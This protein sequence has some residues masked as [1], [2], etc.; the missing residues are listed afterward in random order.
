MFLRVCGTCAPLV[1]GAIFYAGSFGKAY[2]RDFDRPP[3]EVAAAL[4]DLDVSGISGASG[5]LYAALPTVRSER[6]AD[7]FRWTI[8]S[9]SEV[10]LVM[11][12]RITP[13][14]G[15]A[16][17]HVDAR[18]EKGRLSDPGKLPP[19]FRNPGAMQPL[20][21]AA[22]DAELA[23]LDAEGDP[24]ALAAARKRQKIAHG[25]VAAAQV[26]A[27][28]DAIRAEMEK[29]NA[30]MMEGATPGGS[31]AN[32]PAGVSFEPGKPMVDVSR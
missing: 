11:T 29:A 25:Y 23:E 20:F 10:A 24:A 15:G 14:D 2:S 31:S 9:G 12:A 22:L 3:A 7:G 32:A 28:P 18:V 26:A 19:L 5:S 1:A 8:M 13:T 21:V 17:S 30:M 6:T 27:N 16:G 4:S